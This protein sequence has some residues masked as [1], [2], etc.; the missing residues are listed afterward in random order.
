M[1][2]SCHNSVPIVTPWGLALALALW[3]AG[4]SY[5]KMPWESAFRLKTPNSIPYHEFLWDKVIPSGHSWE[6]TGGDRRHNPLSHTPQDV[7]TK[8][9]ATSQLNASFPW[10][11]PLYSAFY[12]KKHRAGRE[13]GDFVVEKEPVIRTLKFQSTRDSKTLFLSLFQAVYFQNKL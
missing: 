8:E 13:R 5:I 12:V 4:S 3:T 9:R 6:Y 10:N 7:Q 2:T 1:K 11:C